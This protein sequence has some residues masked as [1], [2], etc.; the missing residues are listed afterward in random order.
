MKLLSVA[1]EADY[2]DWSVHNVRDKLLVHV[3]LSPQS[4]T[5]TGGNEPN[6]HMDYIR[7]LSTDKQSAVRT[8]K[9]SITKVAAA[10][11]RKMRTAVGLI[12]PVISN[13]ELEKAT[14]Y[15]VPDS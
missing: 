15:G 13:S 3:N 7:Y 4:L 5:R 14:N 10:R 11:R 8:L 1:E 2:S 6:S 9:V 12:P